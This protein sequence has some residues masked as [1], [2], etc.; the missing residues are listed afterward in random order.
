MSNS[1]IVITNLTPREQEV[2]VLIGEGLSSQEVAAHLYVS[3]RTVDF[4]LANTYKKLKV[5]NRV[6]ALKILSV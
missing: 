5:K 2:L 1:K 3:K 4:H 6:Q